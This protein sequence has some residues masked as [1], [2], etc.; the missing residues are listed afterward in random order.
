LPRPQRL[1]AGLP[2]LSLALPYRPPPAPR[3][4]CLDR[5]ALAPEGRRLIARAT[6]LKRGSGVGEGI[7]AVTAS[8]GSCTQS[9]ACSA[10][11][12]HAIIMHDKKYANFRHHCHRTV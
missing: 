8:T 6:A 11:M 4:R 1:S 10:G 9:L 2:A 7:P 12:I 5:C 3:R